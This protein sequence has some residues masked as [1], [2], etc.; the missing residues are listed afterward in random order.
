MIAKIK[1][2]LF[3]VYK[4]EKSSVIIEV[5]RFT[6]DIDNMLINSDSEICGGYG[7]MNQHTITGSIRYNN[8]LYHFASS[9]PKDIIVL[10]PQIEGRKVKL[11]DRNVGSRRK[12]VSLASTSVKENDYLSTNNIKIID[13]YVEQVQVRGFKIGYIYMKYKLNVSYYCYVDLDYIKG[14]CNYSDTWLEHK[15]FELKQT[16]KW[17]EINA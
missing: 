16:P 1:E 13:R 11:S 15:V 12:N 17:K 5:E 3:I 7:D 14:V 4:E 9:R 6:I 2:H 8:V 10:R